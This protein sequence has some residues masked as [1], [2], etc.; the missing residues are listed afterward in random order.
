[1]KNLLWI[2]TTLIVI[3]ITGCGNDNS[4]SS[5]SRELTP[6]QKDSIEQMRK[7]S[8][9]K[10]KFERAIQDS[11][12]NA[13][14]VERQQLIEKLSKDFKESGDEFSDSRWVQHKSA[15]RYRNRN[16]VYLAFQKDKSNK[17]DNLRFIIQYE[18]DDWLFIK[19]IIFN[20]DGE[21]ITFVPAD[22]EEDC[23]NGG[24]IWEWC[25]ESASLGN[26][27]DLIKKI[28]NAKSVKL[29][30]NGRQYYDTR[31]MS[32]D[33]IKGFKETLEYYTAL[34]SN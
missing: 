1:M 28:A 19:N 14:K 8:I 16:G 12:L 11:I 7:D 23:G 6:E 34:K 24:R 13:K 10:A 4:T 17:P 22:M 33:A 3:S 27:M 31:T 30:L 32:A 25:D 20:V 5:S 9:A 2:I 26:N 18:A 29:K 15:P 21:N